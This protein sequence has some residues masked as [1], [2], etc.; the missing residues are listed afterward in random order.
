[1]PGAAAGR[2]PCG[3]FILLGWLAI[4]SGT[5]TTAADK[6]APGNATRFVYEERAGDERRTVEYLATAG[7]AIALEPGG[8]TVALYDGAAESIWLPG[9]GGAKSQPLTRDTAK[10]L[11][12][13]VDE[14]AARFE[15]NWKAL[16]PAQAGRAREGLDRLLETSSFPSP[17]R[18]FATG[19]RG[20]FAG[21]ECTWY[22][23]EGTT[24]QGLGRACIA[25]PGTLDFDR[26]LLGM[27]RL[28]TDVVTTL[29][30]AG[31][32]TIDA[33]AFG[34]PMLPAA[35]LTGLPLSVTI[36]DE[37]GNFLRGLELLRVADEAVAPGIF[38]MPQP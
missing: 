24:G 2:G 14:Q 8:D 23:L 17:E 34:Q 19:D 33:R 26:S 7:H 31:G 27:L 28:L 20:C 30:G 21:Y 15:E 13:L 32:E 5:V 9:L 16:P 36:T 1:M 25:D 38:R 12:Q 22:R 4:V 18:A 10:R 29:G 37:N 3:P 35:T 11:A 6:E